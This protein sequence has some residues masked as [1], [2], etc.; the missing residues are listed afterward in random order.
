MPIKPAQTPVDTIALE[1]VRTYPRTLLDAFPHDRA[2]YACALEGPR[3]AKNR[4]SWLTIETAIALA[5]L[6]SAGLL[7]LW[8]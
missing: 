1:S 7:T 5:C 2:E 8:G 4:K 6:L 3:P